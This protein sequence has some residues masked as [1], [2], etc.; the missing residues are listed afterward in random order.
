MSTTTRAP[1]RV[2]GAPLDRIDGPQ[3]V[4]GTARYAYEHPVEYPLYLYPLRSDI[5]RG[6]VVGIDASAAEARLGVVIVITH[7]NAPRLADTDDRELAIL[8]SDE[9]AFR[10]QYIGAVV[11]E[12]FEVARHAAK[13]VAVSYA[14]EPHDATLRPHSD[15]LYAPDQLNAGFPTDTEEGDVDEALSS[16]AVKLDETYTTPM[17]HNNPMEP[18]T[19][20][21]V[22]EGG[23]LTL[24]DSTQ[25]VHTVRR[26]IARIF[27]L[28]RDRVRVVA[29]HVGGGFG[30]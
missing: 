17:E 13:L 1:G 2:I 28:D 20:I 14:E 12:T 19:T 10:G 3:K 18:H 5:V 23:D 16:A 8:Q 30:S 4:T 15:D 9:V 25:G 11:A 27:G 26:K 7:E 29:P 24:Y 21:A 6:R 22:W